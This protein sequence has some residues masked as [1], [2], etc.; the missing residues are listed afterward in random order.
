MAV[1]G[2]NA[3]NIAAAGTTT[4]K[5]GSGVLHGIV[6]NTPIASAT[7]TIYDNTTA[8]GTKIGTVTLPGTLLAQGPGGAIYDAAFTKGLTVVTTGTVDITVLYQ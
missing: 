3:T 6:V 2:Y 8:T 4:L 1:Q 7:I 5:T